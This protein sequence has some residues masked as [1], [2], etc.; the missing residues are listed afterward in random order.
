MSRALTDGIQVIIYLGAVT[1]AGTPPPDYDSYP[2]YAPSFKGI[3]ALRKVMNEPYE[4]AWYLEANVK[5]DDP[6]LLQLDRTSL[7]R[8]SPFGAW[9]IA[10]LGY[11]SH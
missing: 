10:G 4:P 11:S 2:E 8:C 1:T 7:A 5:L 3:E 9:D 6:L